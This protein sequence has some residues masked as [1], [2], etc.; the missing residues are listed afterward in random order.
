MKRDLGFATRMW[1]RL[2]MRHLTSLTAMRRQWHVPPSQ[3]VRF[4]EHGGL[5]LVLSSLP[6]QMTSIKKR[7][8]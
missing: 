5:N 1:T 7:D 8:S 2:H 6:T 4:A 3:S